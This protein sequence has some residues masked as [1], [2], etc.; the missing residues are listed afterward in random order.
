MCNL[1]SM[2]KSVD[3]IRRLFGALNSRDVLKH[4]RDRRLALVRVASRLIDR[5]D[6]PDFAAVSF[7]KLSIGPPTWRTLSHPRPAPPFR[8]S[9]CTAFIS[10]LPLRDQLRALRRRPEFRNVTRSESFLLVRGYELRSSFYGCPDR[11][12]PYR[13]PQALF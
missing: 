4:D 2:T 12:G 7:A 13:R 10:G 11:N 9:G 8:V 6:L 3:A 5:S 1:Y